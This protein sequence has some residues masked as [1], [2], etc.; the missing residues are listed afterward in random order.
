MNNTDCWDPITEYVDKQFNKFLEAETQVIRVHLTDTR[1]HAC[2]YFI[3]P[4]GH[5]LRSIDV[6]F[7]RR[8]HDKVNIIPVIGKSDACT[9]EELTVFKKKV[10]HKQYKNLI[11]LIYLQMVFK[12]EAI[13]RNDFQILKQLEENNISVYEFPKDET[14]P[15]DN[16]VP[17]AVVGSN[18][19]VQDENGKRVRGR[20]YPWGTVNIEDKNHCDFLALRSLV[21]AHHMQ[22]LKDVTSQ[23]HY[24]KY[25]CT[26]LTA[27]AQANEVRQFYFYIVFM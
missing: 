8:L 19:V 23:V 24:E 7:M 2:L 1:I 27:L 22:D 5:G 21:L 26:K 3:A 13:N 17:F 10:S 4:S 18:V 16:L 15:E 11:H 9:K 25:R 20:K 6:E 14:N 12:S